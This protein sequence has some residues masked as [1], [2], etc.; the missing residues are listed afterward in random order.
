LPDFIKLSME[1]SSVAVLVGTL[2]AASSVIF[3]AKYKLGKDKAK[4]L[5]DLLTTII[6][7]AQDDEVTEKEFQKIVASVKKLLEKPEAQ[8]G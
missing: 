8:P 4:Q 6:K 7:A 2:L 3:G 5:S 1:Y